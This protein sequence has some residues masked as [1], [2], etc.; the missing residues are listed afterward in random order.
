MYWN[1][2]DKERFFESIKLSSDNS[3]LLEK[4]LGDLLTKQEIDQLIKRLKAM[5]LLKDLVSYSKIRNLTGLSPNTIARL[6]KLVANKESGF[7]EI[8]EKFKKQ[9]KGKSYSD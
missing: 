9:G 5:C 4:F 7:R 3:E 1:L 2:T 8:I 6:S